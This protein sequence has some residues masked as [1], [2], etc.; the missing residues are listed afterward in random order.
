V[1]LKAGK[2]TASSSLTFAAPKRFHL[3]SGIFNSG[4]KLLPRKDDGGGNHLTLVKELV[5]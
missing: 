3:G 4:M 5:E 1:A 2:K